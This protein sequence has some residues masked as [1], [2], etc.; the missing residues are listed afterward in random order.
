MVKS[1]FEFKHSEPIHRCDH[2]V[3]PWT[4]RY[5]PVWLYY[6]ASKQASTA[7]GCAGTK[8]YLM[9]TGELWLRANMRCWRQ[10]LGLGHKQGQGWDTEGHSEPGGGL[11]W[12][13][14]VNRVEECSS[15][16][17]GEAWQAEC[18]GKRG[19]KGWR[20]GCTE[21]PA[22]GGARYREAVPPKPPFPSQAL[23]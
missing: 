8:Q 16:R 17:C 4:T 2:H 18:P 3:G 15:P 5:C 7:A 22:H 9:R 12:K 11:G 1:G 10:A 13:E 20:E 14:P 19:Q 6:N 21:G 23:C